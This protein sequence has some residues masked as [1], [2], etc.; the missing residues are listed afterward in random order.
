VMSL[1]VGICLALLH[2]WTC[3]SLGVG[4][5]GALGSPVQSYWPLSIESVRHSRMGGAAAGFAKLFSEVVSAPKQAKEH[6]FGSRLA[7]R[8]KFLAGCLL[9]ARSLAWVYLVL[10]RAKLDS[11]KLG[12]DDLAVYDYLAEFHAEVIQWA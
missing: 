5:L 2:F 8:V 7:V 3:Q 12:M 4:A 10:I 6:G 11:F 1:V 9:T